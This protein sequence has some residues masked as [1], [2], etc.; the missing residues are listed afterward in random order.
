MTTDSP[1][2]AGRRL[3][4]AQTTRSVSEGP[5]KEPCR[6]VCFERLSAIF[7]TRR[8]VGRQKRLRIDPIVGDGGP[9]SPALGRRLA[10]PN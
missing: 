2:L 5:G 4:A 1:R 6:G 7:R 10:T 8:Q 3:R 9:N